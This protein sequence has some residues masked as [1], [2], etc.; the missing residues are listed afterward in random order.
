MFSK[1]KDFFGGYAPT[2]PIEYMVVGLGNPGKQYENTKHNVGFMALD[3]LAG[4]M[5]A[6]VTRLKFQSLCG[7]GMIGDKRVL[8]MKPS[9]FMNK[10][11]EAVRSAMQFYKVPM[12]NVLVLFDDISLE[13]GKLRIRRKGSDGGHNGIKNIIY[14]TGKDTFPRVK[15]GVGGKPYPDYDLADWVLAPFTS[16][17][18]KQV[19]A[20]LANIPEIVSLIVSGKTD[21]AMNRFNK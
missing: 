18:R 21:Q 8:L 14:L 20:A 15:I 7:D 19:D 5:Q 16:D 2:G 17:A 9:T 12:E 4:K 3:I 13:P 1:L 6:N 11:G 10:S